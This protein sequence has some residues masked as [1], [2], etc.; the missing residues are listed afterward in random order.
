M[1]KFR[2][3]NNKDHVFDNSTNYVAKVFR[4]EQQFQEEVEIM[5]EIQSRLLNA[6]QNFISL[7][8]IHQGYKTIVYEP[9]GEPLTKLTKDRVTQMFGCLQTLQTYGVIHRDLSPSH[10]L[11]K[12]VDDQEVVFIIDFGCAYLAP[13]KGSITNMNESNNDKDVKMTN[14]KGSI[15]FAALEI[16][17]DLRGSK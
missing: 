3:Y 17:E 5:Q 8:H 10:F 15:Q 6:A 14:Y 4:T 13:Q 9:F 7:V 1:Y 2:K 12:V 16:L 11:K